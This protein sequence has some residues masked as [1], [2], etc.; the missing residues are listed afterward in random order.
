MLLVK[1]KIK[2]SPI[3]GTGLFADEFIPKGTFIWRF[4]KGFDMRVG[5]DYPDTLQE[6]AKSFFSTYAYQNPQTLHYVLCAD[7]ARFVNHSDNPNTHCTEDSDD[8]DSATIAS[9]DIKEGEELTED[10]REFD[11]NPFGGF[12]THTG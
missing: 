12:D 1:T 9:R 6:P 2:A 5:K 3:A 10:Y 4:K 7:D 11:T 8:E